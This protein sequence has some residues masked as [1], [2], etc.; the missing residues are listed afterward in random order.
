MNIYKI[1]GEMNAKPLRYIFLEFS[2][3]FWFFDFLIVNIYYE[4]FL[5]FRLFYKL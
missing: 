2:L 5:I 1:L 4:R 3:F